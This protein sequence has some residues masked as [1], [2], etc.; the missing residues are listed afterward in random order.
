MAMK[1]YP[2]IPKTPK[3]E[4]HHWIHFSVIPRKP[5]L[6]G[7]WSMYFKPFPR[8]HLGSKCGICIEVYSIVV[9]KTVRYKIY[10]LKQLLF[11]KLWNLI[12]III[13]MSCRRHGYPWPSLATCPYRSSPLVGLQSHI[14]YPHIAA[15]CMFQL[16]I[17]LFPG[18]EWQIKGVLYCSLYCILLWGSCSAALGSVEHPFIA[19][20]SHLWVK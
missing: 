16:V 4:L 1:R 19:V 2:T 10:K 5:F 11:W 13:I 18:R 17:L 3:M 6:V 9:L 7:I 12:I 8:K 20:R 15:E 14:P